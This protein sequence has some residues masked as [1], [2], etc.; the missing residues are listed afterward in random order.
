MFPVGFT[1]LRYAGEKNFGAARSASSGQ[2]PADSIASL[3][4]GMGSKAAAEALKL[5]TLSLDVRIRV[6]RFL[7]AG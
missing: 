7:A 1:A 5:P 4:D 6:G 2:I 3:L